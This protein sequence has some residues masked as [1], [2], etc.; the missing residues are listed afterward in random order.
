MQTEQVSNNFF[1]SALGCVA[2][3]AVA[4]RHGWQPNTQIRLNANAKSSRCSIMWMW[5]RI[6]L[7]HIRGHFIQFHS[8]LSL[9]LFFRFSFL[10]SLQ[11]LLLLLCYCYFW[12]AHKKLFVRTTTIL[13]WFLLPGTVDDD[14]KNYL[15]R[16]WVSKKPNNNNSNEKWQQQRGNCERVRVY[17][18]YVLRG[19]FL[20]ASKVGLHRNTM[21]LSFPCGTIT[22]RSGA[23]SVALTTWPIARACIMHISVLW[24]V[25]TPYVWWVVWWSGVCA[26]ESHDAHYFCPYNLCGPSFLFCFSHRM[27]Y[28]I[29]FY[30]RR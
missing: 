13:I 14:R 24:P 25:C 6:R 2:T 23:K 18:V 9:P 10:R 20:C 27:L 17:T 16:K 15:H 7:L 12:I 26:C 19:A 5:K 29:P 1:V 28:W 11:L 8:S 30:W 21:T 4:V 3:A 22:W